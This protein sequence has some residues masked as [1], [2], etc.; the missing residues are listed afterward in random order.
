MFTDI[1]LGTDKV[2]NETLTTI[3]TEGKSLHLLPPWYDVDT[4]DELEFLKTH[5]T[6]AGLGGQRH[7]LQGDVE[8][9]GGDKFSRQQT[10]DS[11]QGLSPVRFVNYL[12]PCLAWLEMTSAENFGHS[13]VPM[14]R[15]RQEL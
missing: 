13:E 3:R 9:L 15:P 1:E 7:N 6:G 8:D 14:P 12:R 2:L 5:L 4:P 11:V 10:V